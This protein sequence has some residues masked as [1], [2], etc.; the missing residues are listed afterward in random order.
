MRGDVRLGMVGV[1]FIG[2]THLDALKHV[3]GVEVTS[4]CDIDAGRAKAA[5]KAFDI[6]HVFTDLSDLLAEDTVDA[7][8]VATPNNTHLPL[9]VAALK[10]GKHV[11]CEKPLAMNAREARKMVETAKQAGKILMTGQSSRYSASAQYMKKQAEA[12]RFG[13]IY[14]GK[15]V[16]FRRAGIPRGWFQDVK[17]AAAG[18]LIDL[19]VHAVDLLWWLMGHP[20]P[21]SAFAVTYDHLGRSGQGMGGWGV[22]YNPAKF[23][24][25]DMVG[26]II[27]FD[28]GQAISIDISWASHTSEDYW[29]RLF[30]IK[31][32]AQVSPQP[33]IYE[34]DGKTELDITPHLGQSNAYVTES[35]HFIDCIRRGET[36]I[37]PGSQAVTV[38]AMLDALL[39]SAKSG[40]LAPVRT[41]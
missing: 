3:S 8:F 21:V 13:P 30:G 25:E 15:A 33:I 39:A 29:V 38:M 34:N 6:P 5:A 22:G 28:D 10:A 31:G 11:I 4:V 35:Q 32:G 7:V 2:R 19:G 24:V 23:S 17:Q 36:P 20:K 26:G 41:V 1:G 37:S 18:P 12:G 40:R 9:S 14:Y 27:R 16:W